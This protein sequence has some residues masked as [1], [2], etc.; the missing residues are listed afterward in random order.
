MATIASAT[1]EL[2]IY[3][4]AF[5]SKPSTP[6]YTIT[7][8]NKTGESI[9]IFEI[10]ELVRDYIEIEFTGDYNSITQSSWGEWTLTKTLD[11]SSVDITTGSRIVLDGYGYFQDEINPELPYI[12][13]QSN[14][15]MYVKDGDLPYIP[16]FVDVELQEQC[17]IIIRDIWSKSNS[18]YSRY[19]HYIGRHYFYNC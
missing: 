9:I 13:L 14:N 7:K 16:V 17:F 10:A 4:G 2:W 15:K 1:L 12:L 18:T 11:D 6:N 3:R 19:R 8:E 5:G